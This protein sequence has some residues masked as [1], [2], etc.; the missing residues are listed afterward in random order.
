MLENINVRSNNYEKTATLI[1][2]IINTILLVFLEE[3]KYNQGKQ[4]VGYFFLIIITNINKTTIIHN[5][6][7]FIANKNPQVYYTQF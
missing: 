1:W 4:Y 7:N 5:G 6:H 2:Y 3:K